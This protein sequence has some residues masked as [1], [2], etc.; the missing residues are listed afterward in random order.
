LKGG[1]TISR[2][3]KKSISRDVGLEIGSICGKYFLKLEHLHY[4]YWT[5]DIKLDISNL[6]LAQ[7]EYVKFVISHI[8]DGVKTILDVGCGTGQVARKLLDVGYKVDGVSPSPFLKR[9]ASELLGSGS[10]IFECFYEDLQ[11]ANRYDMVLFCES[12]QYIDVQQAL[13]KTEKLLNDG[14]YLL[15]CDIF[16]KEIE[17]EDIM[18]GGHKLEKFYGL[19][20]EFPFRLVENVDITEET[21]P[22]MDLLNDV[23][24]NVARPVVN[25]GL[26]LFESQHRILLKLLKWWYR[27]KIDKL[28]KKYFEGEKTGEN[29]R[30]YKS[31]QLFLYKKEVQR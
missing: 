13:L 23:L 7:D 25:A 1:R 10:C 3:T 22:N 9:C 19:I 24:E 30:K 4:G 15:I 17:G 27:K 5:S 29:F 28:N 11:T 6:H 26:R 16:R 12:F 2:K 31:Y 20:K 14:G 8:P 21:A 18:S